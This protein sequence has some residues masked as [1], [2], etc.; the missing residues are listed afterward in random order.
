[1]NLHSIRT[2]ILGGF[3]ALLMLQVGLA[4]IQFRVEQRV[5]AASLQGAVAEQ[6]ANQVGAVAASLR[7]AQLSLAGFLR[8]GGAAQRDAVDAA[9]ASL[10]SQARTV[11][12][13]G[14]ASLTATVAAV[15]PALR[16]VISATVAR[17]DASTDLLTTVVAT[18]NG[19]TAL[20]QSVTHA[21]DRA[22]ADALAAALSVASQPLTL[23]TRYALNPREQDPH[24]GDAAM[25]T[26]RDGL[27]AAA[28]TGNDVP[29]RLTRLI[30]T[31]L[32]Q[33]DTIEPRVTALS[34]DDAAESTSLSALD[35]VVGR[36]DGSV[37]ATLRHMVDDRDQRQREV[38]A[39]QTIMRATMLVSAVGGCLLGLLLAIP[40]GL[41]ITRPI[42]RL[43]AAMR[44]I[45]AGELDGD[46]PDQQ[47]RDEIGGMA[48]ALL[49]MRDASARARHL[50]AEAELHRRQ[51]EADRQ[52]T[53]AVRETGATQQR[54]VVT[55]LATGLN[56][57]AAGNLAGR[58]DT[59]FAPEYERL[60]LDFNTTVDQLQEAMR[61]VVDTIELIR[62]GTGDIASASDD[63]SRRTEQQAASLEQTAA[64]LDEI[65]A[66]VRKTALSAG[67]ARDVVAVALRDASHSGMVVEKAVQAMD[68]IQSSAREISQIIGLIDEVAFQTNLLALNAGVEAARAGDAGRGFAVVASEVRALAQRTASAAKD[69]KRLIVTSDNQVKA[70]VELVGEAGR[71]L[72]GIAA[73]V[74]EIDGAVAEIAASAQEQA[75]GLNEVN[76]AINQMDQ[77]TQQNAAMVEQSTAA[78][79]S[80]AQE[81]VVLAGM[82]DHFRLDAA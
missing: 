69:I 28:K 67:H 46:V 25:Q 82:I 40:V 62:A 63:L 10:A 59:A 79:H 6:Q 27:L 29:A 22:T 36:A 20:A 5:E 80:L 56:K 48:K 77:V 45:A 43:G 38:Q 23:A 8:V 72:T 14:M 68:G 3:M 71:A 39:A 2:R 54:E 35:A 16:D 81:T 64:A 41:S 18:Q 55:A 1:M 31:T 60:R 74:G 30:N 61:K 65:T 57:L 58:L 26:L 17:R 47:R 12:G 70:G 11:S 13:Q 52:Q 4:L 49:A 42:G 53:E 50:E 33:L 66:T 19:L 78:A 75:T 73:Q 34:Q 9:L 37:S 51:V 44:R 7:A 15:E 32:K 76:T 24:A 21:P